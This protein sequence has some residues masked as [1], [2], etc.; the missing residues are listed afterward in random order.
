MIDKVLDFVRTQLNTH[1]Q[2]KLSLLP[3][4]MPLYYPMFRN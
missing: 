3:T 4:E 2:N 1:L